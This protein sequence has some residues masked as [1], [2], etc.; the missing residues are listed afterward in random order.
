MLKKNQLA[1]TIGCVLAASSLSV[2]NL[3]LAQDQNAASEVDETMVEEVIVT[4]SRIRRDTFTAATPIDVIDTEAASVQGLSDVGALLQSTTVAAGSS[5]VTAA[6]STAFVQNGGTGV[7][8]LSLR[9]LGPS[10][11][12]FLLNGR[13]AGPAGVRGGVSAFDLNVLPLAAIERVEI[14]K[15][16][17]SSIYG[18]DA[19]AGV[20]NIITRTD[21]G[22]TVEGYVGVP[23]EGGGEETRLSASWG[24]SSERGRFRITG[25]YHLNKELK[26]G[27]RDFLQC[28][29]QYIFDPDT[30]ARADVIDPRTN[31]PSCRDLIWGH[32]W[33]YDYQDEGGNVPAG[34][35]AQFDTTVTWVIMFRRLRTIRMIRT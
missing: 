31:S 17:A 16:G 14:L 23:Q 18:S 5:Q 7:Q 28:P 34:A 30:G 4:G 2:T 10:R 24:T 33:I 1:Y 13:R 21:D 11:T 25:D 29:E 35:K 27:D 8:T 9:G 20:V 19:V 26:Y 22:G 3:A 12:L 15:D 32:V 6:T